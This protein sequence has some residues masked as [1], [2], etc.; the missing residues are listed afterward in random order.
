MEQLDRMAG[1]C[2]IKGGENTLDYNII[3]TGSTGNAV[4]I[5][6][7][8]IDCGIP[9]AKM[10][11]D[12]Y[13]VDTLLITHS[14][15]DHVKQSTLDRIRKE[16][17]GITVY[18]NPDVA[19]QFDV[20]MVVESKPFKLRKRRTIIPFPGVHDVP[21]TGY[22]IQMNKLNILYMTDTAK[23]D[24][25]DIPLDYVFLESNFDERKIRQESKK[26]K[27]HG[28]D[29]YLSVT[30]HLST[31][32]CKEFYFTHRRSEESKL[33]ELHQSHRFY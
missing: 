19:Y 12:L 15:S 22:I 27:R 21:V 20:D 3:A 16:F 9:F 2:F 6:N 32:K 17:P 25:P 14:H 1:G 7:I 10:K 5:E 13:K 23:V 4:R 28:Y 29:P 30:R 33:I 24:P 26:Y 18:A 31:Q 8:M 11:E